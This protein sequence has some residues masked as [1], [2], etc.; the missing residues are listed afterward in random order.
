MKYKLPSYFVQ[1]WLWSIQKYIYIYIRKNKKNEIPE[2]KTWN[3]SQT[4][5][6][7]FIISGQN[8]FSKVFF[9]SLSLSFTL[10]PVALLEKFIQK[11]CEWKTVPHP[12]FL[13]WKRGVW[14][15][16]NK[17]EKKYF[18]N[19]NNSFVYSRSNFSFFF[20]L[21]FFPS[22]FLSDFFNNTWARFTNLNNSLSNLWTAKFDF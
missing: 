4:L 5:I 3:L 11:F 20:I 7:H 2:K 16:A 21:A 15:L 13:S 9:S 18:D 8:H 14:T 12:E 19:S 17:K 22:V 1:A 6:R 10:T